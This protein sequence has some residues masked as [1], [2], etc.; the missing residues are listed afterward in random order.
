MSDTRPLDSGSPPGESLPD[1]RPG[2]VPA[3]PAA[4]SEPVLVVA[5]GRERMLDPRYLVLQRAVGWGVTACAWSL[6]TLLVPFIVLAAGLPTALDA[7]VLAAGRA[8][9]AGIGWLGRRWPEL[10]HRHA[11]YRVG[12][13]AIEIKRG[14]LWRRVMTVPRSRIQHTDVSQGP[15]ARRYGLAT[16]SLYTAGTEHQK[17]DLPGL[18]HAVATAIRDHLVAAGTGDG[19]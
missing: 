13:D 3:Q 8:M 2:S 17:I 18:D 11:S 5:D 6:L 1:A 4:G 16:L 10:E 15:L 12:T 9:A 14:V 7:A 19:E